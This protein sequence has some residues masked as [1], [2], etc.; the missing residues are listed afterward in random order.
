MD[1]PEDNPFLKKESLVEE[2]PQRRILLPPAPPTRPLGPKMSY[3]ERLKLAKQAKTGGSGSAAA[4]PAPA[5]AAAAA[6]TPAASTAPSSPEKLKPAPEVKA[7]ATSP[8]PPPPP[9]VSPPAAA[10]VSST[11]PTTRLLEQEVPESALLGEDA[12]KAKVRSNYHGGVWVKTV[13]FSFFRCVPV[14]STCS[15]SWVLFCFL[16]VAAKHDS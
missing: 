16:C 11:P 14:A 7:A 1:L 15:G 12:A 9:A 2:P 13:P 3:A 4:A 5:A 6:A 10:A 8:P